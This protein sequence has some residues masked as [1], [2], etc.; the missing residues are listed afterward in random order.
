[1]TV[2]ILAIDLGKYKSVA[3]AYREGK[4][5]Q[6]LF[7]PSSTS[8]L[9][10]CQ[11]IAHKWNNRITRGSGSHFADLPGEPEWLGCFGELLTTRGDHP[12]RF[13]DSAGEPVSNDR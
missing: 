12:Y 3:C 2:S 4:R 8:R 5:E 11:I 13:F 1:M 10:W 6:F 7:L 9:Y